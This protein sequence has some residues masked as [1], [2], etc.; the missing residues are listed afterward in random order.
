MRARGFS[1]VGTVSIP[2]SPQPFSPTA[3]I[4][5]ILQPASS[6]FVGESPAPTHQDDPTGFWVPSPAGSMTT[7]EFSVEGNV[8]IP[9][10]PQLFSLPFQSPAF[11]S[12]HPALLWER[13]PLQ[14]IKLIQLGT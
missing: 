11:F 8:S 13:A 10:T 9:Q 1:V 2:Q 4:S 3:S 6:S 7:R 5:S 14:F 12:L